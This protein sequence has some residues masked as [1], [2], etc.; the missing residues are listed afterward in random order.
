V[1]ETPESRGDREHGEIHA[2]MAEIEAILDHWAAEPVPTRDADGLSE[3]I[4]ALR[5]RLRRH[6][7]FEEQEGILAR[8]EGLEPED[9]RFV[10]ELLLQHRTLEERLSKT[11]EEVGGADGLRARIPTIVVR[12]MRGLFRDIRR[13]EAQEELLQRRAHWRRSSGIRE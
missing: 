7:R 12:E 6:F 8:R 4:S 13:H 11:T 9:R 10:E 1:N 3:K 2:A 5:A